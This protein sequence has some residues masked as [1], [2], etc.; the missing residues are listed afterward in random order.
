MTAYSPDDRRPPPRLEELFVRYLDG[1]LSGAE[2][3]ELE[4]RLAAST[5]D[6]DLFNEFCL[7]AAVVAEGFAAPLG[8]DLA[9]SAG[10]A[11]RWP[12]FAAVAACLALAASVLVVMRPGQP[13]TA[14]TVADR[15]AVLARATGAVR[16]SGGAADDPGVAGAAVGPGRTVTTRGIDA[17]ALL[18]YR[19]GTAVTLSGDTEITLTGDA[20]KRLYVRQGHLA[21]D[22]RPQ[23]SDAPM[24]IATPEAEVEVVGTMLSVGRTPRRTEVG[25][26]E[27]HARV[28]R[29]E[30]T[31]LLEVSGGEC[32]V[33]DAGGAARKDRLPPTPDTYRWRTDRP[34]PPRWEVGCQ[35]DDP[36]AG[37]TGRVIAPVLFDDPFIHRK[38]WQVRSEAEW[39]RGLFLMHPDSR[40]RIRYRVDRPGRGQLLTVVRPDPI[41]PDR[42]LCNVMLAPV[43]FEPAPD[44]GWRTL[45]LTTAD[46]FPEKQPPD[47][48]LPWLAFLV[49]FNTYEDDLGLRIAEFAVGRHAAPRD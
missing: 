40:F 29:P 1:S 48:P 18:V 49:V 24:T 46:W 34:L 23:P 19:D 12:R 28:S 32:G 7:Q 21:A 25:V 17:S 33:V 22:V 36:T 39:V 2:L 11:R 30:G 35:T 42:R 14:P 37:P 10:R 5:D 43:P 31:P 20:G 6:Q 45:E 41:G 47:Y 4:A 38:C 27:G 13:E 26:Q 15:T 3:A 9:K 8:D 44:G 16:V